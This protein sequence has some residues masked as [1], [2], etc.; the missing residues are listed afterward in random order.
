MN[1]TLQKHGRRK[2]GSWTAPKKAGKRAG[3]KAARRF[4]VNNE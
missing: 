3:H 1:S 2:A 4:K